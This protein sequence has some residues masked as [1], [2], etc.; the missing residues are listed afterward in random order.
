V[1]EWTPAARRL[2][3]WSALTVALLGVVYVGVGVSWLCSDGPRS[4]DPLEPAEPFLSVLELLILFCAPALVVLAA[5]VHAH[6]P[7]DRKAGALA[8]LGLMTAFAAVTGG[9]HFARLAVVRHPPA[10]AAA[11]LSL[12]RLYPWPSAALALDLL[13]WDLFLGLAMLLAAPAFVGGRL[14]NAA[15]VGLMASGA[16]CVV[17][18]LGPLSGELRLQFLAI[19]AYAVGLPLSCALLA[20]VFGRGGSP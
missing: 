11:E 17:G 15:R 12:L 14:Q 7:P 5:A 10:G 19:A 20:A 8:A 13:A 18:F 1:S 3:F 6:A 16:L 9:V 4:P 2:G